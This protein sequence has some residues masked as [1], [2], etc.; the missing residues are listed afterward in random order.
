MET[1]TDKMK[2]KRESEPALTPGKLIAL[3]LSF[4]VIVLGIGFIL[5]KTGVFTITKTEV[6]PEGIDYHTVFPEV[7]YSV[8]LDDTTDPMLNIVVSQDLIENDAVTLNDIIKEEEGLNSRLYVF[9]KEP[10]KVSVSHNDF[11]VDGLKY[12]VT[13]LEEEGVHRVDNYYPL[14]TI[15]GDIDRVDEW[16]LDTDNSYVDDQGV[17]H[18]EGTVSGRETTE[19][20]IAFLKGITPTL[21][22]MN[23]QTFKDV[24]FTIKKGNSTILYSE[25]NPKIMAESSEYEMRYKR[26]REDEGETE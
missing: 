3:L 20:L 25:Q 7:D 23:E 9:E 4:V 14:P 6:T 13:S 16:E 11:Y 10:T 5:V 1:R 12:I 18:V 15:S 17:L 26:D 21:K 8:T 24:R 19:D 22:D 2:E